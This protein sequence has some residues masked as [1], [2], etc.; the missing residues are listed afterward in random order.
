[1]EL[2]NFFIFQELVTEINVSVIQINDIHDI[3]YYSYDLSLID[4][5]RKLK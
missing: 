5:Y 2:L 1:M 4:I 3:I